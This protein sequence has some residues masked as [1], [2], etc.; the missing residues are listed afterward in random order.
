MPAG[1]GLLN[2]FLTLY[3]FRDETPL[4][5]HYKHGHRERSPGLRRSTTARVELAATVK[6][7]PVWLL[8][9]FYFVYLGAVITAGGWVV[10]YLHVV[11]GG[12]LS[13]V[14][15]IS[16]AFCGGTALGRFVLAEPTFRFGE[17]RM[18][19][20]YATLSLALEI[21]FWRVPNII[22]N[23]V[24]VSLMGFLLGPSFATG[25]SV[26]SKLIPSELQSSRLGE[27]ILGQRK[28]TALTMS[29][30]LIFVVAQGG[31][32]LF[33]AVTGVISAKAG[34]GTLQPIPVGLLTA[35]V[36][37][38]FIAPDPKK[39]ACLQ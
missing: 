9:M 32:A 18:L 16:S 8:S 2:V 13:D 6:Q 10:E 31:G 26:A 24:M 39:M 35:M 23:S 28:K 36:V 4:Y 29:A 7:K 1:I 21:M 33:P 14:G 22:V 17:K 3:A 5:Q 38:W 30:A 25:V 15:Y 20:I 37:A 11:R 12:P 34:V 19:L 27:S